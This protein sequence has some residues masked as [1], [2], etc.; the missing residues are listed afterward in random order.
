MEHLI[1]LGEL[2]PSWI[3]LVMRSALG[4]PLFPESVKDLSIDMLRAWGSGGELM[5]MDS[6]VAMTEF[7]NLCGV[8][9]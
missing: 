5:G 8:E 7:C 2:V 4:L 3:K 9:W 6:G 1:P